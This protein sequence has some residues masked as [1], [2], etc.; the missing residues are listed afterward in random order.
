MGQRRRK[1]AITIPV[2]VTNGT[3]EITVNVPVTILRDTDGDGDPDTTDPDDDGDKIMDE[4]EKKRNRSEN[5]DTPGNPTSYGLTGVVKPSTVTENTDVDIPE[6][7]KPNK[8]NSTIETPA[9]VNGLRV[10]NNGK[11]TGRPTVNKWSEGEEERDITIPVKVKNGNEE[12]NVIVP[13]TIQRDTDGDGTPDVTD[14]DDDNDGISDED[15]KRNGT[16]PKVA[17]GLTGIV[18]APDKVKEKLQYRR[19]YQKL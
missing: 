2:K 3:E 11:L 6:V 9:E 4:E 14:T 1:R 10:D 17:N 13:V 5:P 8:E 15:E 16:D 7:V 18:T 19:L 12:A